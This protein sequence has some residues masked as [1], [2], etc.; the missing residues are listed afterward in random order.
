M[1]STKFPQI[2]QSLAEPF[3]QHEVKEKPLFRKGQST[4][5]VAKYASQRAYENRLDAVVGPESWSDSYTVHPWGVQCD[6]TI[7]LPD[8]SRVT[9]SG[10]SEPTQVEPWK[11]AYSGAF[12][13]AA[14]K[15]G[16]GRYL[17]DEGVVDYETGELE[18]PEITSTPPVPGQ[19]QPTSY[20]QQP[21][22]PPQL[23]TPP[24][25][26]GQ[27]AQPARGGGGGRN[28]P[29]YGWCPKNGGGLFAWSKKMEEQ[30]GF[31]IIQ[32]IDNWAVAKGFPRS[33][34]EWSDDQI[35]AGWS[36][37]CRKL[38]EA[39]GNAPVQHDD[40]MAPVAHG[41]VPVPPQPPYAVPAPTSPETSR[42]NEQIIVQQR[43]NI[44]GLVQQILVKRGMPAGDANGFWVVM[45]EVAHATPAM[46]IRDLN[47]ES[48]PN[49][50]AH[51][52]DALRE[53]FNSA[54]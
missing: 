24:A 28:H 37:A 41:Y 52:I 21:A 15:F 38:D 13:I 53:K 44:V 22:A 6:L 35:F 33:Y 4:G 29:T 5:R 48:D 17:Y 18:R 43:S 49:K 54:F 39:S 50:L 7:T 40:P 9:K 10:C 26:Y 2:F 16:I 27:T 25:G 31:K 45:N 1:S 42:I 34:K 20:P 46:A 3:E 32:Y 30:T 14:R 8:G 36:E 19:Y 47:E 23:S 11:G 51:Y 12:K